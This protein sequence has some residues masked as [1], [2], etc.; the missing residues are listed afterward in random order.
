MR[1]AVHLTFF[2]L[3]AVA[4]A[5]IA[6]FVLGAF[7]DLTAIRQHPLWVFRAIG[8]ARDTIVALDARSVQL[9]ADFAPTADPQGVALYRK[10]CAQCHGAPGVPPA[11]FALGM[12]PVPSN[13]VA[14]ARDRP[15]REI[16]WFIRFGLK[17][18]GM[19]AWE[20][21]MS[22]ADMWRLTALVE[23]LPTL[24]P[25]DY[26]ALAA[27]VPTRTDAL[28]SVQSEATGEAS[29]TGA[30]IGDPE[31]GRVAMQVHGCL[32]CH[33]IP[34]LVGKPHPHVGP[35]LGEAGSRRY[36][37]GVLRNTPENMVRWIMDPQA[38][39]PLS[40]MP[41]LG[42]PEALARDMAAYLYT[43]SERGSSRKTEKP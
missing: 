27:E 34:G 3:G 25:A 17:M 19:P 22:E 1:R 35:T 23:A 30:A 8:L 41:D 24:S 40:A 2:G 12:M 5:G 20:M 43:V 31:R 10:H 29:A 36:I 6:A 13:L 15:P 32:Q 16:Y 33:M 14:A 28:V 9:P 26:K 11:E 42:V 18:S 4:A 39:D 38:V 21:R 37:A 7:Y